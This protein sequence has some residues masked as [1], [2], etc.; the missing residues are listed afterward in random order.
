MWFISA[1]IYYM[2]LSITE[3]KIGLTLRFSS[4]RIAG[5]RI[6]KIEARCSIRKIA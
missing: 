1:E 2:A 5:G 4:Q 3:Q 6:I